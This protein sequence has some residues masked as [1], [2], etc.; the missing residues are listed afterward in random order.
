M[1]KVKA[2]APAKRG[3]PAK[4][5]PAKEMAVAV[6][7]KAPVQLEKIPREQIEKVVAR[8]ASLPVNVGV[9]LQ[10]LIERAIDKMVPIDYLQKLLELMEKQKAQWAK[11]RFFEDL[12][13]AQKEFPVVEKLGEA[14]NT[15]KACPVCH[16][17]P[18]DVE[19]C[20]KCDGTGHPLMYR[21]ALYEDIVSAIGPIISDHGFSA[22]TKAQPFKNSDL[23]LIMMKATCVL[24]HRDGHTEET[25]IEVPIGEGTKMMSPGQKYMAAKTFA[26]R[27]AYKDAL[28]VAERGEDVENP[29]DA[30]PAISSPQP[31]GGARVSENGKKIGDPPATEKKADSLDAVRAEV[32]ETYTDMAK[33]IDTKQVEG[34]EEKIRLFSLAELKQHETDILAHKTDIEWLREWLKTQKLELSNRKLDYSL[35]A[36]K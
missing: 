19:K 11:E 27:H 10:A 2:K 30:P 3:R 22:T 28:G 33:V 25:T 21:Y 6:V 29:D 4:K 9:N 35:A 24:R 18:G 32:Q 34:R 26:K 7:D 12:A 23:D 17:K 16:G 1:A 13:Y 15:D 5:T 31:T 20:Q 8:E 14:R 36:K